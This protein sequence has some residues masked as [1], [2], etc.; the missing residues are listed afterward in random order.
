MTEK[1]LRR[2]FNWSEKNAMHTA[3]DGCCADCG[4]QLGDGWHADHDIPYILGGQTE[5]GN[6]R[7]LCPLCNEKKGASVDYADVFD[8]SLRSF[9][10][11]TIEGV[12]NRVVAGLPLSVGL[13]WCGSGKTLLYQA[14]A[15]QLMRLPFPERKRIK[16]VA[17]FTPRRNLAEQGE[18]KWRRKVLD[19]KKRPVRDKATGLP[20]PDE[21]DYLL[22]DARCRLDHL[23]HRENRSPLIED[24]KER[25]G[26]LTT[27][28]SLV[29][30]CNK[31]ERDGGQLHLKWARKHAGEFLLVA[32][33]AQYCGAPI[34]E[35]DDDSPAAGKYFEQMAQYAAHTL[36]L[37][38]QA[39]RADGRKLVL[40]DDLYEEDSKGR[41]HLRKADIFLA[42][43]SDGIAE[44]YLR[45]FD[46][47]IH[48][49]HVVIKDSGGEYDLSVS[50]KQDP[51]ERVA[52]SAVLRDPDL[53]QPM[54]DVSI[55]RLRFA[56]TIKQKHRL[57]IGCMSRN[58][59]FEVKKY[60]EGR[61]RGNE[62]LRI[63]IAVSEQDAARHG[64]PGDNL[65]EF[66]EGD[67][68]V[69]ISVRM[70]F[71][72]YDCP[73]ITVVCVLTNY[74]DFGHLVQ[75]VFRGGRVWSGGGP[76]RDQRLHLI[77]PDD[78]A[79][80]RFIAYLR[81]EQ[82]RGIKEP[83]DGPPPPPPGERPELDRAYATDIRGATNDSDMSSEDFARY[84]AA[85]DGS[86][87]ITTP[88]QLRAAVQG[89]L[90]AVTPQPTEP[91]ARAAG[92]SSLTEREIAEAG[93]SDAAQKIGRYLRERGYDP[94]VPHVYRPVRQ[95]LT[96]RIN[97]AFG[98]NSAEDIT[99]ADKAQD[100]VDHVARFLRKEDGDEN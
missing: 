73:E 89:L 15:T 62:R 83:T 95:R 40:C 21:G 26:Y 17:V 87:P 47:A 13:I 61:Y 30:D 86:G 68:D 5:L 12:V 94:D 46:A 42:S 7:P 88:E 41:L 28:Q 67:W 29:S 22:F 82:A 45:Q 92:R 34:D 56:Q 98:V 14:I 70:A 100:Y 49:A 74:R 63:K 57:L 35:D 53:W 18:L 65:H 72:G 1:G 4:E 50:D 97:N 76:A 75:L 71:I 52:L 99:T 38:G 6:G 85:L 59:A 19:D 10:G 55:Q 24:G 27:Y 79:M 96:R 39:D 33:E 36:L 60:L 37:T 8:P 20:V 11:K 23:L 58:D 91:V 44:G 81:D 90:F 31:A 93:R 54:V 66:R 80:Q 78:P 25:I 16:Y 2:R 48:N 32:D 9:Q 43:Y 64:N 77:V 69:L 51:A 3:W 84:Q